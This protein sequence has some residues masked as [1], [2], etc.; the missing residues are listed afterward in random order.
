MSYKTS[1]ASQVLT[2]KFKTRVTISNLPVEVVD[3]DDF[4]VTYNAKLEYFDPPSWLPLEDKNLHQYDDVTELTD[5]PETTD[6]NG[7]VTLSI[8][9][10]ELSNGDHTIR[11]KYL[12]D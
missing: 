3:P 6:V 1:E 11:V 4:P 9:S 12:G 7:D 10:G 5:S 8:N 2:L